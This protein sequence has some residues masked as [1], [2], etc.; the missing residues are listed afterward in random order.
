MSD[1]WTRKD[2]PFLVEAMDKKAQ[3]IRH[4][5]QTPEAPANGAND[6]VDGVMSIPQPVTVDVNGTMSVEDYKACAMLMAVCQNMVQKSLTDAAAVAGVEASKA[7]K[8]MNAWVQAY[9]DFPFPF[10]NFKNTQS[11]V[12]V[13]DDFLLSADP[14]VVEKI[15]NIKKLDGLKDAVI[16]ALK[17]SEGNLA[18]HEGTDQHFNYFGV[19]T[20]YNQTE[21]AIRVIKFQ[22]NV[23]QTNVDSLCVHYARTR[24]D[25]AYDTYQFVGDK[26]LM[27]KMQT[28]IG[29]KVA[30]YIA[31]KLLQFI[32]DFYNKELKN[33]QQ[34]LADLLKS[35]T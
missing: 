26:D 18:S 2:L 13:K 24:L 5:A 25:S 28:K 33:Y 4:R 12:Y 10:F 29:D 19:I 8:N 15:V 7:L 27:I 9:V 34:K 16:G 20:G 11:N 32:K 30:D 21:I 1:L 6:K 3:S 17:K 23:K 35:Y 14:E 31:E 22:M